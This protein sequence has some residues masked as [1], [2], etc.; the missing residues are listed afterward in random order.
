MMKTIAFGH[1][2]VVVALLAVAIASSHAATVVIYPGSLSQEEVTINKGEEVTWI[3]A[4]NG[5]AAIEG[6]P[7]LSGS[8]HGYAMVKFDRAG[9]YPY[10]VRCWGPGEGAGQE[11][12]V[13]NVQ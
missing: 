12:G 7:G 11:R 8:I 5:P 4:S 2:L 1:G 6:I 10:T 13:I 3:N 9:A